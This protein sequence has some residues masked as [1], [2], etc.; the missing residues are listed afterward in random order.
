MGPGSATRRVAHLSRRGLVT[1]TH[2]RQAILQIEPLK[3]P[4]NTDSQAGVFNVL[5]VIFH[6]WDICGMGHSRESSP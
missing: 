2:H 4:D 3:S 1:V 5:G 6:P